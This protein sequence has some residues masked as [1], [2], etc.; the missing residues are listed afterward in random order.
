MVVEEKK[1]K[2]IKEVCLK[3]T[4]KVAL[5]KWID[6]DDLEN[7]KYKDFIEDIIKYYKLEKCHEIKVV[8]EGKQIKKDQ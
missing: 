5:N 6:T 7:N 4:W 8:P 2:I 1:V 3:E